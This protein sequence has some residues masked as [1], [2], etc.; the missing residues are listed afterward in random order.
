MGKVK[1]TKKQSTKKQSPK[2]QSPR[3]K[4]SPKNSTSPKEKLSALNARSA[5]LDVEGDSR[6]LPA[7]F[8]VSLGEERQG[9]P[10][11]SVEGVGS[12]WRT[13]PLKATLIGLFLCAQI[14]LPLCYYLEGYP[15]DER[16]SWRM[17]ST[18]RSLSCEVSAWRERGEGGEG[19]EMRRAMRCP[20]GEGVCEQ[21]ALSQ[22]LHMVWVN[23]LKRGRREVLKAFVEQQCAQSPSRALYVRFACPHPDAPHPLVTLQAPHVDVCA[24]PEALLSDVTLKTTQRGAE[25]R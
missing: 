10:Q 15:W 20:Q 21:I 17:F 14:G 23:L 24:Q 1:S 7:S 16:F 2:K 4:Q 19:G 12:W 25:V 6:P 3:P 8:A 5:P 18:V 13:H 9:E 11:A 22:E